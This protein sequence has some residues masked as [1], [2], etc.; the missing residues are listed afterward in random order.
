MGTA[1]E[2]EHARHV[3]HTPGVAEPIFAK[4]NEERYSL[5]LQTSDK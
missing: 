3:V 4:F 1:Q 5:D 2:H